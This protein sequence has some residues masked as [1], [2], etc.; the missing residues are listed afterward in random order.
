MMMGLFRFIASLIGY[1]YFGYFIITDAPHIQYVFTPV[2]RETSYINKDFLPEQIIE[3]NFQ[4]PHLNDLLCKV[5][6]T[7]FIVQSSMCELYCLQHYIS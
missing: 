5:Q 6:L 4:V 2:Y 7:H 3:T 1:F